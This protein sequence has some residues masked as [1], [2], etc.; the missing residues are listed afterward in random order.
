MTICAEVAEA[1]AL[2]LLRQYGTTYMIHSFVG[3]CR[4]EL[5][6]LLEQRFSYRALLVGLIDRSLVIVQPIPG[7]RM[8][9]RK[10]Y[11]YWNP[12]IGIP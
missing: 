11:I 8:P 5:L 9:V 7:R 10:H 3:M 6:L 1:M 12:I 2:C 4:T